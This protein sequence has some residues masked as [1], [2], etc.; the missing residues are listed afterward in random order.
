MLEELLKNSLLK[1]QEDRK[2]R[3]RSG[4]FNPSS[5]GFC[6][7]RQ[8]WNRANVEPSNP[9]DLKGLIIFRVGKWYHD[10]LESVLPEHQTEVEVSE[11]D[12]R[13]FADIVLADEV[14]DLKSIR[15]WGFK[16]IKD[17]RDAEIFEQ[18]PESV[19]QVCYYA[20]VLGKPTARLIY[21]AKDSHAVKEFELNVEDF[22]DVIN[23]ELIILRGHWKIY[24]ESN[25]FEHKHILPKAAAR[26][27]GG[28]ECNYCQFRDKCQE[29]KPDKKV[30]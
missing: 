24:Q 1:E 10:G 18:K 21:I 13:G 27:Y 6:F 9:P 2:L 16:K 25:N 14:I 23:D 17:L 11:Y 22:A 26:L 15:E 29:V 19:I 4:K 5:F 20:M 28:K 30:F 12:V 7:R 3:Q 8:I